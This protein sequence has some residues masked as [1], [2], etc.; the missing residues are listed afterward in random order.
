MAERLIVVGGGGSGTAAATIAKRVN[1]ELQVTLFSEFPDIAYSPCGIPYA[2][3]REIPDFKD[4][5]LSTVQRYVDDGL[6]MRM[7]TTV[8]DV[9]LARRTVTARNAHE[10]FDKLILCTGFV[11]EQPDVPGANLEGLHYVKDIRRAMEFDKL[12]DG[13]K[14]VVVHGATPLGVEMAGNLGHRGLQVDFVD[15]GPWVLSEVLDPDVA[16]PVHDSLE[17]RG[18]TL[19]LGTR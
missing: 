15:E 7:E 18:V 3:G 5:F 17:K 8:T 9:D 12:L 10:G 2:H 4:L 13:M 6:D 19:R 14:R 16:A 11:W 1:P